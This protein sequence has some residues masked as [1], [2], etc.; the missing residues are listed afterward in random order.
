MP[1]DWFDFCTH[2]YVG[3][4]I[5][6][7]EGFVGRESPWSTT[8]ASST[9]VCSR[10]G[11]HGTGF[12]AAP[13]RLPRSMDR[14]WQLAPFVPRKRRRRIKLETRLRITGWLGRDSRT[15]IDHT[16]THMHNGQN[17]ICRFFC[18]T[19]GRDRIKSPA[20]FSNRKLK[21]FVFAQPHTHILLWV[22]Y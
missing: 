14:Q 4:V 17:Q 12:P 1:F 9:T 19:T 2:L 20:N 15:K 8:A 3:L 21:S 22:V 11:V 10:A 6:H 7:L 16:H 13:P 5:S 18:K